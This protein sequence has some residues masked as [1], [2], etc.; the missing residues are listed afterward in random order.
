MPQIMNWIAPAVMTP[1]RKEVFMSD[2]QPDEYTEASMQK[3]L[4]LTLHNIPPEGIRIMKPAK[5]PSIHIIPSAPKRESAQPDEFTLLGVLADIRQKTGVGDKVMLSDLADTVAALIQNG[6]SAIDTNKRLTEK[7]LKRESAQMAGASKEEFEAWWAK[8]N[9]P[10]KGYVRPQPGD[11]EL[12]FMGWNARAMERESA[13]PVESL[14]TENQRLKQFIYSIFAQCLNDFSDPFEEGE[15]HNRTMEHCY[16]QLNAFANKVPDWGK[17]D[18][19]AAAWREGYE[20]GRESSAEQQLEPE[21][22][23]EAR[24]VYID[25]EPSPHRVIFEVPTGSSWGLGKYRI[26]PATESEPA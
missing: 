18:F 15:Q 25:F 9:E 21:S 6:D 19:G 16:D 3:E 22:G 11:K 1:D 7:L 4:V 14:E 2:E 23:I 5:Y 24:A 8:I 12:A 17:W 26:T 10:I 20:T 13:Q